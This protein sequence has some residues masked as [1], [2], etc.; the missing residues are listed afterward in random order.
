MISYL[1]FGRDDND[2]EIHPVD[3][4]YFFVRNSAF[5]LSFMCNLKVVARLGPL[6]LWLNNIKNLQ[7]RFTL[8]M[9]FKCMSSF[10]V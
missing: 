2:S 6:F 8:M 7:W 9:Y 4:L 3:T 1:A 10:V 5:N